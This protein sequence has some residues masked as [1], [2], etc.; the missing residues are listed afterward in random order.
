MNLQGRVDH[1]VPVGCR[2]C[3]DIQLMDRCHYVAV[4][5]RHRC[6]SPI[7]NVLTLVLLHGTTA[8]ILQ[9]IP[10]ISNRILNDTVNGRPAWWINDFSK[11]P[12]LLIGTRS[13]RDDLLDEPAERA[14]VL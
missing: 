7:V 14:F 13:A 3:D 12:C 10:Q 5:V 4:G 1:W 8:I 9:H 11:E 6:L 2:T